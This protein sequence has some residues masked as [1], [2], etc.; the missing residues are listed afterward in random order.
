MSTKHGKAERYLW[1]SSETFERL[2]VVEDASTITTWY[3]RG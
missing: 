2:D 3:G 1:M